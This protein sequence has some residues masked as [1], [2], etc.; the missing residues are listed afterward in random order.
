MKPRG[1]AESAVTLVEV[2]VALCLIGV[3]IVLSLPMIERPHRSQWIQCF[4]NMRQLYTAT[5]QMALD[6]ATTGDANPGLPGDTGGSFARWTRTLVERK[7]LTTNELIE[8]LSLPG[9]VLPPGRIPTNN[10]GAIL[11]Y[12]VKA[13]SEPATIFL[14]SANFTNTPTGG[15]P[16]RK[17]ARPFGDKGFAVLRMGG[18]GGFYKATAAGSTNI[19]GYAPLCR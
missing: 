16:P 7:Y 17:D 4:N 6:G 8:L 18:D 10:D 15:I 5:F 11:V 1:S 19:G 14:T 9:R 13:D 12:A 3:L 2:I